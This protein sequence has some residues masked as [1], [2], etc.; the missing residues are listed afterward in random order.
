MACRHRQLAGACGVRRL[1]VDSEPWARVA[2]LVE[3][4]TDYDGGYAATVKAH[5]TNMWQSRAFGTRCELIAIEPVGDGTAANQSARVS[6]AR[7]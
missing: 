7:V 4:N 3:P 1:G 6:S 2:V 5:V